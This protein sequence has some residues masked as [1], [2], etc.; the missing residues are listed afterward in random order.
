MIKTSILLF[1]FSISAACA[2][3]QEIVFQNQ[4]FEINAVKAE[5]VQLNGEQVLKVERDLKVLPFDV[6]NL[7]ATV[8][9]PT[10]VKLK[11]VNLENGIIEVKML[12]R[13]QNPSP[14]EA[15][16][17]LLDLPSESMKTRHSNQSI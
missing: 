16:R 7:A 14:F 12:S 15:L 11:N 17:D 13:V 8:D 1:A 5:V 2:F 10:Y 6:K 9:E 4:K 3:G